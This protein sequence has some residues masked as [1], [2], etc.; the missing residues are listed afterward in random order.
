MPQQETAYLRA[1]SVL[2]N[3]SLSFCAV[4]V[5]VTNCRIR[6]RSAYRSGRGFTLVELLVVIGIIALLIAMLLPALSKAREQSH[7][8]ACLSNLRSLGQ[9]MYLYC[10][11]NRD[12]L[13]NCSP[14]A[15]QDI[16]GGLALVELAAN[17][18]QPE[19]F[20][21]PSDSDPVPTAITTCDYLLKE[22]SARVSYEFFPIWWAGKEGPILS[23]MKGKAPLAWDL[24]GGEANPSPYQ[25]HGTKGGNILISD[26]HAEWRNSKDWVSGNWP[27]PASD[28]YPKP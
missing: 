4:N 18:T 2:R 28:I 1:R 8:T 24:D 21:C 27:A 16:L 23:R 19:I 14:T 11:S 25:N 15:G 5:A 20:H 9:S 13:P 10:H 26:G 22:T 12:R 7:R 17:Y 3:G 6:Q